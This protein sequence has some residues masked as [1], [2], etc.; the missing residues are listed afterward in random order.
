M[1]NGTESWPTNADLN[2]ADI[3]SA[4]AF[5]MYSIFISKQ[6]RTADYLVSDSQSC[7]DEVEAYLR[8]QQRSELASTKEEPLVCD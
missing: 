1:K 7:I 5:M 4:R 2:T 3:A 8:L 6:A